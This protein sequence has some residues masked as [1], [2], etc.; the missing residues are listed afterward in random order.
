MAWER[1]PPSGQSLAAW[2]VTASWRQEAHVPPSP[3]LSS[4]LWLQVNE[5]HGASG[6]QQGSVRTPGSDRGQVCGRTGISL[7]TDPPPGLGQLPT[8]ACLS[9]PTISSSLMSCHEE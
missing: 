5:L 7:W 2:P 1:S 3:V 9:F 8:C 6:S 4:I